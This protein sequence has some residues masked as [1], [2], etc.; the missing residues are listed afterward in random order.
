MWMQEST[1]V[2]KRSCMSLDSAEG[3]KK[4][5]AGKCGSPYVI[6]HLAQL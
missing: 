1:C 3:E 5:G 4:E 6:T 2:C